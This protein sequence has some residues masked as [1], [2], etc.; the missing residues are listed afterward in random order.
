MSDE[1]QIRSEKVLAK[2]RAKEAERQ[3]LEKQIPL[4]DKSKRATW[5]DLPVDK[6]WKRDERLKLAEMAEAWLRAKTGN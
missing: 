2:I 4:D 5:K 3:E 6:Q 1:E